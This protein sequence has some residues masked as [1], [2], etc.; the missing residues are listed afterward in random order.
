M[1]RSLHL[2]KIK[3]VKKKTIHHNN[4]NETSTI[5]PQ[6]PREKKNIHS[7]L[8]ENFYYFSE[9]SG[10][11][12]ACAISKN[13]QEKTACGDD[14][15]KLPTHL[16]KMSVD[17]SKDSAKFHLIH[18]SGRNQGSSFEIEG[19]C[20]NTLSDAVGAMIKSVIDYH[21]ETTT[22]TADRIINET[23]CMINDSHRKGNYDAWWIASDAYNHMVDYKGT[24]ITIEDDMRGT[25][26]FRDWATWE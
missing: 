20:H 9:M 24:F 17:E 25:S 18:R 3:I 2:P 6:K 16:Q 8:R 4:K 21:P 10:V 14:I 11:N 12:G 1:K 7:F 23:R 22:A 26:Y 5:T 19:S 13:T 15:V